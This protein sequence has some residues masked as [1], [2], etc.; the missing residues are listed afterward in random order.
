MD[1]YGRVLTCS[2]CK[3][4]SHIKKDNVEEYE[5]CPMIDHNEV[6]L[7]TKIF[8]GYKGSIET[9]PICS[10]FEPRKS[11]VW[12]SD[13]WDGI[14]EYIEELRE[15]EYNS[16]N[17]PYD[18]LKDV[19]YITLVKN[20][21]GI[22]YHYHVSLYDWMTDN[23]FDEDGNINYMYKYKIETNHRYPKRI[24]VDDRKSDYFKDKGIL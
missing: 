5:P 21:E 19:A 12:L 9:C 10:H 8:S 11:C 7:Y 24:M 23:V 14:D 6:K 17:I 15:F 20:E 4:C 3:Y 18:R 22:E 2:S 13:I 16:D 1:K